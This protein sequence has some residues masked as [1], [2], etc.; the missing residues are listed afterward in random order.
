M[1]VI[2]RVT[3]KKN[4]RENQVGCW[5]KAM[6]AKYFSGSSFSGR[7]TVVGGGFL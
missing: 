4:A 2:T 6:Y 7:R 1:K 3:I 5:Y